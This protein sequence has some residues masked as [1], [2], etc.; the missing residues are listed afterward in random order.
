MIFT[1][2][3]L[4]PSQNEIDELKKKYCDSC[5]KCGG[6][7]KLVEDTDSYRKVL[8]C[9]CVA[10]FNDE[11]SLALSNIPA[12]L[13]FLTKHDISEEFVK[14]NKENWHR[15]ATYSKKLKDAH[16]NGAGLFIHGENGS[17]KS[18][19]ATLVLKRALKD[20]YTAYFILLRKLTKIAFD[21]LNNQESYE[22]L[23][24]LMTEIDFLVIDELDKVYKDRNDLVYNLLED[25]FKQRYYSKKPLIVTSN[26]SQDEIARIHGE[27]VAATL[28]E[29][30]FPVTLI[31]N[32]RPHIME[33]LEKSFFTEK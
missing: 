9:D 12:G 6:S 4:V 8:L 13:R 7:R 25:L 22:N 27:T 33:N 32:Y 19:A 16:D 5:I 15:I 14:N 1:I 29:R 3:D 20:G 23:E 30:L 2:S 24:R 21:A 11:Y 10:Q 31:G 26:V 17:G 28:A 18:F